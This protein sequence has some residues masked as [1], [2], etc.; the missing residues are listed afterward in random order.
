MP[1]KMVFRHD[2]A[3]D[4]VI[5]EAYWTIDNEDDVRGWYQQWV[6]YLAPFNRK[7]DFIVVLDGMRLRPAMGTLWGEYRARI[8][9]S[10]SRFSFRVHANATTRT[11]SNTSGV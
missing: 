5:A 9:K 3:N 1:G 8:N 7:V 11:F 2:T 6:E 4:I 10:Y